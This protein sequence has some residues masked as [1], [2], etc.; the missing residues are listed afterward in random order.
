MAI[1]GTTGSRVPEEAGQIPNYS[2]PSTLSICLNQLK[3]ANNYRRLW[4]RPM[5]NLL[6]GTS[7]LH[8]PAGCDGHK[9]VK[10]QKTYTERK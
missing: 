4:F 9:M 5:E 10:G 6:L 8:I 2:V 7:V 3:T 1:H